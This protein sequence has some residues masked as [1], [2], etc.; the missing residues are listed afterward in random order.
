MTKSKF[1]KI[2]LLL[3]FV[4]FIALTCRRSD[5]EYRQ[6]S[7]T[8]FRSIPPGESGIKFKNQLQETD[9][10]NSIFYEYYY[11]GAGLATGD[12]N[13]DGLSD[14]VFGAN[15]TKCRIY[16][17]NGN[18]VFTDI[19]E[20]SGINTTGKWITGVSMV[21]INHDGWLDIY[22]CAAGNI[23]YDYHNLLYINNGDSG[24]L[25]FKECAADVGLDDNGYST[26]AEFFDYDLDG[27]LD[28][29]IVTAAMTTPNKNAI[30]QRKNDGSM[31]NTD[32]LYRNEGIDARTGLPFFRNVSKQ[33]GVTWDGFGLGAAV[34][35]I[36][37]D[38]WPDI[39]VGNDYISNDLLYVNQGDG[40][41]REM[42]KD[43]M[44]HTSNST[45]GVDIA[46]F[47]NDGLIDV[48]T[49]DMQPEDYFRKRTMAG[50][51]RTYTRYRNE[52]KAGY[53]PQYVRNMLHVNM[54]EIEGRYRFSE[55]GQ[56]AGIFETD[57][58]W[59]PLFADF[60]ND[61]FKDLFIGNGIGH[62]MTNMDFSSLWMTT[63]KKN[64][65]IEFAVLYK[66]L[67][68]DLDKRGN[69]KKPN[70]IF[71][72]SGGL[73]FENKTAEWGLEQPIYS[74]GSAFSD[75]DNDGDLDLVLNNINDFASVYENRIINKDS[76]NRNNHYLI[77]QLSGDSFNKGGIGA[78]ISIFCSK[79]LQYYEH[80][81]I[82]GFQ[83]MMDPRIHFGLGEKNMIDSLHIRWPDGKEQELHNLPVNQML[84][85]YYS[86]SSF[87]NATSISK[88]DNNGF[89]KSVRGKLNTDY[90]HNEKVFV[91]F[92]Y[93]PL[94]PH[95]YS[96]EGPGIAVGDV[97]SDGMDDFFISGSTGFSGEI[98]VQQRTGKFFS[99]PLPGDNNYEDMGSLFFDADGDGDQDL[100]IVSGGSGLPPGSRYYADRLYINNGKGKFL[101]DTKSLPDVRV[102]GSQVTASDFDKDGDLDLFVCGRVDLENYPLPPRSFLLRNDSKGNTVRFA[103]ITS[104]V[105]RELERPG[106]LASSV[107]TDFNNDGWT[108]LILAGEWMP[109]TFFKN[110]HGKLINV[111]TSTGIESYTGWWN[112]IAG[113]DFDKDG[114]TD[115][116]AGNL[117]L[118]TQYKV[119]QSEPMRIMA[120]DFDRN[121]TSD[122]VCSYYV[123]GKSYPIY[124]RNTLL[125]QIPSLRNRYKTYEDYAKALLDDIFPVNTRRDAYVRESRLFETS[126][127]EN[128][129]NGK[130]RL[131]PLPDEAQT[132]PIYGILA[133]DYNADGNNDILLA[134]NSYST[135]IS[136]GQY[137][138]FCGL[139]LAGD[140]KGNFKPVQPRE[141]GFFADGDSKAMAE[142]TMK[143]GSS[144]ILISRNSD[145][146]K[147]IKSLKSPERIIR[148]KSDDVSA[149][150]IYQNG[151]KEYREFYYGSGYLSQ[152]S[153]V[154]KVPSGV[155]T[156][157]LINYKGE[158]R[159]K[160]LK[161]KM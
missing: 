101:H 106:L 100:Y 138:S 84:T 103:D 149:R 114:D 128:L 41:F 28:A 147:V 37:K 119:S 70:V 85:L 151:D 93:Q 132:A 38:G 91:D 29:Y 98:F 56:M 145:S 39:Y 88:S 71:R 35:D 120:K 21:D 111:T 158:I 137:D 61:G 8:Q 19:T 7:G 79:D 24:K 161:D 107:W 22:F 74:P 73:I 124:Q 110:E 62:D 129:G 112:S 77:I 155:I 11:N 116:V 133:N 69:V 89:F 50:N 6:E 3:L 63:I 141:S 115:Y 160:N 123:Q 15:M 48:L 97:N 81:P 92:E 121:G 49:L 90:F 76:V 131:S 13:N 113:A 25:T 33:A 130:F 157:S 65:E 96:Q 102:C 45:M 87:R 52:L 153:R 12:L 148:L 27:D 42:L 159:N 47:N 134:G 1:L 59:A 34:C 127:I 32:R 46:D 150:L 44:K 14:I 20:E 9:S 142:L 83:A 75:L 99:Y 53:S 66:L 54:G 57:W 26:Q 139:L 126:Y 68:N 104:Q 43:Y 154:C 58:S 72:N 144:I 108:D 78:K 60:D 146:L 105:N 118:N 80:F 64:P 122:P 36:N 5:Q 156:V 40:T 140:G 10:A 95:M 109:L 117:G 31:I 82:R 67:K 18:F 30:R 23:D 55:I 94:V 16:L 143:D 17:N 136:D 51:M 86:N 4:A 2:R 125:I 135:S 152:S